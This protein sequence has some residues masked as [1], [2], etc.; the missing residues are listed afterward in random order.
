MAEYELED[1][2]EA[3][4]KKYAKV[5]DGNKFGGTPIF[6]QGD[7]FP[8]GGPWN[9]LLQLDSTKVPFSINFGDAGNGYAFISKDVKKLNSYLDF[10]HSRGITDRVS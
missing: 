1:W 4:F 5:L 7:E 10:I 3:T 6:L 2:D 9:R 8:N